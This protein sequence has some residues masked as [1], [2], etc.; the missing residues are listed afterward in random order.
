LDCGTLRCKFIN[1][2]ISAV[3]KAGSFTRA[4]E[5]EH[6]AQPSLSQQV[7]KLEEEL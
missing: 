6:I 3:A 1:S 5:H 2:G 4:A 7:R